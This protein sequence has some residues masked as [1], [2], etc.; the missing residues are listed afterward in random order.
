MTRVSNP[1]GRSDGYPLYNIERIG[2]QHERLRIP[3]AVARVPASF[4][5]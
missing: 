2:P 5:M 4:S 1:T 3:L